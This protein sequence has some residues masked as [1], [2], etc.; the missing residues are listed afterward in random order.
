VGEKTLVK[1]R[2]N[3]ESRWKAPE[4]LERSASENA[5]DLHPDAT[6]IRVA[7]DFRPGPTGLSGR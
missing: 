6:H 3:A 2:Q 7:R 4:E 5:D 1:A